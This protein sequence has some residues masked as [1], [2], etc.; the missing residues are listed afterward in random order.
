MLYA[1]EIWGATQFKEIESVHLFACKKLLN[2]SSRTP[3]AMT[4]GET[5][6]YPLYI[7]ITV[8]TPRYWFTLQRM[9]LRRIPRQALA[10]ACNWADSRTGDEARNDWNWAVLLKRSLDLYGFSEMC[11]NGGV[12]NEKIFLRMFR[13][14]MVDCFKQTWAGKLHDSERFQFYRSFKSLLQPEQYLTQISISKSRTSLTRFRLGISDLQIN[15]RYGAVAQNQSCPFC[16]IIE[17]KTH[18][19]TDCIA[20]KGKIHK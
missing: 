7:D 10:M 1:S 16:G 2:V 18:F 3:N 19:L 11:L 13:Q 20:Y 4:Y 14:R 12:G 17:T 15:A 8:N 6:R 9:D 5:G